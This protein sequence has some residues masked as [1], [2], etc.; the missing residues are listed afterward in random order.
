MAVRREP[1][2][3][4]D[5]PRRVHSTQPIHAYKN[6]PEAPSH[7]RIPVGEK[8]YGKCMAKYIEHRG[9]PQSGTL[10]VPVFNTDVV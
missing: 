6:E 5:L 3:H 1:V 4:P 2:R 9:K 10:C 8:R 7:R